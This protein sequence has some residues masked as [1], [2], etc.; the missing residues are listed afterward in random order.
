M[1][2]IIEAKLKVYGLSPVP[3]ELAQTISEYKQMLDM[4]RPEPIP[5]VILVLF[6]QQYKKS[7]ARRKA[8]E[9]KK[10]KE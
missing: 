4:L 1:N 3:E 10:A 6:V 5:N 2:E 7:L 8:A 9:A